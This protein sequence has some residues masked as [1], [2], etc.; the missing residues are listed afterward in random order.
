MSKNT[1]ILILSI[2][3]IILIIILILNTFSFVSPATKETIKY[4]NEFVEDLTDYDYVIDNSKVAVNI[5]KII[6]KD[7]YGGNV[8]NFRRVVVYL[9]EEKD[10]WIVA[11]ELILPIYGGSPYILID[12]NTGSIIKVGHT[13]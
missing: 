9:D 6:W 1:I 8:L 2:L 5:A 13:K 7:I 12:R 4:Y 10:I 11:G 3:V